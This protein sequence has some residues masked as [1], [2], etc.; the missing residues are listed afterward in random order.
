V[1][2]GSERVAS[3][4]RLYPRE[5]GTYP[6]D[7]LEVAGNRKII[8]ADG[9]GKPVLLS[10]F[11]SSSVYNVCVLGTVLGLD[12][13]GQFFF[14]KIKAALIIKPIRCTNFSNLFLE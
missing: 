6:G 13:T 3:C 12:N 7:D 2:Y 1:L 10:S 4:P 9:N 14:E 8:A 11:L 5:K